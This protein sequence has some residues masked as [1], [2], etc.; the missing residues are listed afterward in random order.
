MGWVNNKGGSGIKKYDKGGEVKVVDKE[1]WS[2]D[3]RKTTKTKVVQVDTPLGKRY[4]EG[5]GTSRSGGTAD[6]LANAIIQT[7]IKE[8]PSDS[9]TTEDFNLK[10]GKNKKKKR[11][12]WF[13]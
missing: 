7:K 9:L 2:D 12:G 13:K 1:D 6:A 10:Y 11:K 4:Y 5:I 8:N 3:G